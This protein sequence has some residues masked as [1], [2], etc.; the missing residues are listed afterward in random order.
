MSNV[1]FYYETN[2]KAGGGHFWRCFNFAKAIKKNN[3]IFFISNK[4]YKKYL[5]FLNK[6]NFTF[7]KVNKLNNF[8]KTKF[9]VDKYN[10]SILIN[11]YYGLSS[12]NKKKLLSYVKK[13]IVVDDR[14][15]E[16]HF[17]DIYINNNPLT[18]YSI[19]KIKKLNPKTKLLLG[20]KYFIFNKKLNYQKK[21]KKKIVLKDFFLFFGSSDA[22]N[23]TYKILNYTKELNDF[24]FKVLIG[25]LNKNYKKIL[26]Y[27][28]NKSNIEIYYNQNNDK[29]LNLIK[30]CDIS[31]GAGGVN[32]LER[33]FLGIPSIVICN[34]KNQINAINILN[35]KNIIEYIGKDKNI[36]KQKIILVIKK[37]SND[38]SKVGAL[39]R[40]TKKYFNYFKDREFFSKKINSLI[41]EKKK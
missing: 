16:K 38:I 6:E 15:N 14:I 1:G 30:S 40:N 24:N 32:L 21:F 31:I 13:F 22:T 20:P 33:L 2:T 35:Q 9:I 11:D 39:K 7:I 36:T 26:N 4:K 34:A 27:A 25:N 41:N 23:L 28:K 18:K 12:K 3:K 29:V 5:K 37:F 10:I 19:N 8:E 17:C